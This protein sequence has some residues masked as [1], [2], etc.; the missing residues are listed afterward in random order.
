MKGKHHI[1]I[2]TES[3]YRLENKFCEVRIG[4]SE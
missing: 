2:E 3:F 1:L 4:G